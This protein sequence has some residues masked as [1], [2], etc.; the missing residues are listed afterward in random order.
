MR[1]MLSDDAFVTAHTKR[2]QIDAVTLG[3]F[4]NVAC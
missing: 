1:Q 4:Q 2:D 3:Y